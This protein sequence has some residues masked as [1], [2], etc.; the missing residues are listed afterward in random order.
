MFS[1]CLPLAEGGGVALSPATVEDG[2]AGEASAIANG[3]RR[4][5]LDV[6]I[7]DDNHDA[8]DGLRDLLVQL[9]HRVRA[10]YGGEAALA[11]CAESMPEVAFLDLG[12][13]D[14]DG[15]EAARRLRRG[16]GGDRPVLV[17]LTGWGQAEDRRRTHAAGFD[18]HLVKPADPAALC[19]LL[20]EA[21]TQSPTGD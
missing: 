18:H 1:V 16:A 7:A 21:A 8:A 4:R 2:A 19:E 10:V 12:M 13:P 11:A 6:L 9:G 15:Y 14:V 5:S 17:A 20:D 3:T